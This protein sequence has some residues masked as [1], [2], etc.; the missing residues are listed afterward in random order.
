MLLLSWCYCCRDATV[1]VMIL[2]SWWYGCRDDTVVV[3]ILF[4]CCYCSRDM[5]VLVLVLFPWLYYRSL[6]IAAVV[7]LLSYSCCYLAVTLAVMLQFSCRYCRSTGYCVLSSQSIQAKP[8]CAQLVKCSKPT[9]VFQ[10]Y[11]SLYMC[12]LFKNMNNPLATLLSPKVSPSVG[13]SFWRY[14]HLCTLNSLHSVSTCFTLLKL[15]LQKWHGDPDMPTPSIRWPWENF[16]CPILSLVSITCSF[17]L[18][19]IFPHGAELV[20]T[21]LSYIPPSAP[22][23]TPLRLHL[24]FYLP[25]II[26]IRYCIERWDTSRCLFSCSVCSFISCYICMTWQPAK[27]H[28]A[29]FKLAGIHIMLKPSY[30]VI[31]FFIRF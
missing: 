25:I 3:M 26:S 21:S 29:A 13:Y 14:I 17:L 31:I 5:R 8:S 7:I 19:L 1:V 6:V 24:V 11:T 18:S 10:Y 9:S 27:L 30:Y 16:A 4:W 28:H 12:M 20:F 2:L 15:S 22:F 23:L